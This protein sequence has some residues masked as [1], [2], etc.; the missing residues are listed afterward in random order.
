MDIRSLH[1]IVADRGLGQDLGEDVVQGQ[2]SVELYVVRN[3]V[4]NIV[5]V[6]GVAWM[7][8]GGVGVAVRGRR[9]S[10]RVPFPHL[11]T[12]LWRLCLCS[13]LFVCAFVCPNIHMLSAP[14]F[15]NG[16]LSMMWMFVL[17]VI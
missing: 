16:A 17:C 4:W 7:A 11:A 10:S 12:L 14:S 2:V 1:D 6:L 15:E 5:G 13:M 8:T 9:A 3:D